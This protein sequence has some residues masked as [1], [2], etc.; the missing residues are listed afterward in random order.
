VPLGL[1]GFVPGGT[2]AL[3]SPDGGIHNRL[4]IEITRAQS[5]IDIAIYSFT[6]DALIAARNR[7]VSSRIIADSSQTDISGSVIATLEGLGFNLK[8]LS[9]ISSGIMPNKFMIIDGKL[10]VAGAII[11]WFP[12]SVIIMRT[13]CS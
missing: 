13:C 6:A 8:R 1:S 3:F 2:S 10:L 9:G 12:P 5:T 7:D 11:G 4:I